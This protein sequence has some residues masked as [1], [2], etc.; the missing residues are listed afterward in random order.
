VIDEKASFAF[1]L[2]LDE[3]DEERARL[4]FFLPFPR[5]G[6]P[7]RIGVD[8]SSRASRGDAVLGPLPPF[9][10]FRVSGAGGSDLFPFFLPSG[11]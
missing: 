7:F 8:F 6:L 1:F 4:P 5:G 11:F 2:S 3:A 9:D 10:D